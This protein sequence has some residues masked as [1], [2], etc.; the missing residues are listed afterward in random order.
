MEW[1][2]Q[3]GAIVSIQSNS[4]QLN[5]NTQV[6]DSCR[7]PWTHQN[8][9]WATNNSDNKNVETY[10]KKSTTLIKIAMMGSNIQCRVELKNK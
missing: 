4:I 5:L 6:S 7:F 2:K 1:G 10:L 3:R 8:L 9:E